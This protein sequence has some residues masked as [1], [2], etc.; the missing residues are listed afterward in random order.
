METVGVRRT[1]VLIISFVFA[2]TL[3]L[4]ASGQTAKK[5][6]RR[7]AQKSA[8]KAAPAGKQ[9]PARYK[10]I[11]EPVS[12]NA[13][14]KLFD[15]F[16]VT[17]DEGW[18]VG[19]KTEL[20]GGVILHTSDA[21]TTWDVQYGDPESSERAVMMPRFLDETHGWA[22]QGTGRAARLL[23]TTDGKD[24]IVA[25]TIAEHTKDYMFVSE[26]TGVA[27]NSKAIERT[28]DGGKTWKAVSQCQASVQ[29]QGLA[30]NVSCE[31]VRVQFLTPSVGYA[32]A[33]SY[34]QQA[35]NIIFL[36]KTSDSGATWSMTTGT[37]T[38]HPQDAFFLDE[39][40]GYVRVGA[41]DTGQIY[42]T[43]NG[44]QSW[45]GMAASPGARILFADPEVGWAVQYN[46]VSFTTDGGNRWNSRQYP[47]PA[48]VWNFSLPRRDRG[49]IVG[50][51]GMIYRYRLVPMDYKAA[52]RI[53]APLLS[54]IASPLDQQTQK[55]AMVV[56]KM[57]AEAG[58]PPQ[59]DT[60]AQAGDALQP[61]NA[62]GGDFT[63]EVSEAQTTVDA[64]GQEAAAFAGKYHNLNLLM[65]GLKIAEQI[66]GQIAQ[67]KQT[68]AS[69]KGIKSPK[70]AAT[71]LG[72][73]QDQVMGL[74]QLVWSAFQK[75]GK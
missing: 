46:K 64:A 27:L 63:Q 38:D 67:L 47:F 5:A 62:A 72:N 15:A 53:D 34:D 75:K 43:T 31:W 68:L 12:Y 36:A 17:A 69:L 35:R 11:W 56:Q 58:V 9:A 21:G 48:R 13:D 2:L 10:G 60:N 39:N 44:G 42:K 22:I 33:F 29:L 20:K 45:T 73:A 14:L 61:A 32:V 51:H 4:S 54:G 26:D 16:F 55:L 41:A 3:S 59:T 28:T 30:R 70:D 24:W 66:P 71:V 74:K 7:P 8:H 37:A 25:G 18:V 1:A 57:A 40:T 52:G 23:H 65:T 6:A 49:Y 19:G 50:E